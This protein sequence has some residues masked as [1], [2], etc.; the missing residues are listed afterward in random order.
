MKWNDR[1]F[2]EVY[3]PAFKGTD[4]DGLGNL[5]IVRQ[6]LGYLRESG[7]GGIWL[8]P[9]YPSRVVDNDYEVMDYTGVSDRYGS[10]QYF[11][12]LLGEANRNDIKIVV[13]MVLNHPSSRHAWFA[14]S[15]SSVDNPKRDWY[16]WQ[17]APENNWESFFG[18][19]AW[20]RDGRIGSWY[21][22]AFVHEMVNLNWDHPDLRAEMMAELKFWLDRGVDG[23]WLDVVNFLKGGVDWNQDISFDSEGFQNHRYDLNAPASR[24]PLQKSGRPAAPTVTYF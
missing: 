8:T 12:R 11:D 3:I 18:G 19:S 6:E 23:L 7:I 4:F 2:Y 16:V 15:A 1:F 24:S 9:F 10:L 13:D 21:Y 20:E 14:E 17:D 22:L 5:D